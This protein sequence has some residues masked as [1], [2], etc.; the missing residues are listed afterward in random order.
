MSKSRAQ[1]YTISDDIDLPGAWNQTLVEIS[2]VVQ[3]DLG[4]PISLSAEEQ[5][6]VTAKII[7]SISPP[8]ADTGKIGTARQVFADV[9]SGIQVFGGFVAQGAS[10]VRS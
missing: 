9:L 5:A 6:K 4:P 2:R 1:D 3:W 7:S 8:K 10:V